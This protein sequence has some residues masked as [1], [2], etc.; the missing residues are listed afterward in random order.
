MEDTQLRLHYWAKKFCHSSLSS[1]PKSE[2]MHIKMDI[3]HAGRVARTKQLQASAMWLWAKWIDK[4]RE[5]GVI[6]ICL[7]AELWC[8]GTVWHLQ[9]SFENHADENKKRKSGN[10]FALLPCHSSCLFLYLFLVLSSS[11]THSNVQLVHKWICM[12]AYACHEWAS[13][14]QRHVLDYP[15]WTTGD[16]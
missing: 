15:L 13:N 3:P 16:L 4:T 10:F 7:F 6:L 2:P 14:F 8:P 12:C 1:R 11:L 9:L 5:S